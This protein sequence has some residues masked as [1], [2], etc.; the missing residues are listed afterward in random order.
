M[1]G[2][3]PAAR[4]SVVSFAGADVEGTVNVGFSPKPPVTPTPT[5]VVALPEE[6]PDAEDEAARLQAARARGASRLAATSATP[7]RADSFTRNLRREE[8]GL[9]HRNGPRCARRSRDGGDNLQMGSRI[10]LNADLAESFGRWRLGNDEALLPLLTSANVACGFHAGDA[11]TIRSTVASCAELGVVVGA[12]VSYRDLAGFGRRAMEVDPEDLEAD[13]LYQVAAVDGLAR[14]VGV[15]ARYVKPHG[16]LYHRVLDDE[17]QAAAL[18]A[19]VR[20]WDPSASVLTQPG[21][22][23]AALAAGAGLGVVAEAFADRGY[24]DDGRLLPRSTP[25]ALLTDPAD[26]AAQAVRLAASGRFGSRCVHGDP[27]GAPAIA[28]A[29]RSA[30]ADAGI[31]VAAFNAGSP[32]NGA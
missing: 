20:A 31:D 8:N 5:L 26:A 6:D 11:R 1:A 16:A 14:T 19:A 9:A 17:T 15:R 3:V 10:D 22:R 2:P 12:Q 13:V 7:R 25:G 27:P 23:L 4:T 29:V 32:V 18:V 28:A 21:G 30:L 24:G